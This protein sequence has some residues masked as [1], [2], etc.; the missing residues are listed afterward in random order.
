MSRFRVLPLLGLLLF[1]LP[2][3]SPVSVHAQEEEAESRWPLKLEG[4][5]GSIIIY[6]PQLESYSG[7]QLEA[8]AAVQVNPKGD[9][10]PVFGA[11]WFHC[12]LDTDMDT[13]TATLRELTITEA[14][15]PDA[16]QD[17]VDALSRYLEREVPKWNMEMSIDRLLAGMEIIEQRKKTTDQLNTEPPRIIVTHT[18]SVLILIDGDPI[19]AD[20]EDT[21]LKR[22]VNTPYFIVEDPSSKEYFLKG[23]E[24]W[25]RSEEILKG[26][27]VATKLPATVQAVAD[28]IA[29][30]EEKQREEEAGTQAEGSV[31]AA[32]TEGGEGKDATEPSQEDEDVV[33]DI[34]VSTVAA[35]LI[36]IDGDPSWTPIEETS[37]L[38]LDN[39]ESDVLMDIDSQLY[40]VLLAGRWYRSSSLEKGPW[41]YVSN[42]DLPAGFVTI[43]P[44][45]DMADV[46]AN[47]PGTPE[48]R[49]AVLETN[50]PQT[51]EVDRK[52]ATLTVEYD[53][54]PKFEAVGDTDMKYAVNTDK[55]VL[56]ID[57]RYYCCD[58]AIWFMADGPEGPWAVC[59]KVPEDV[60]SIP[61]DN[62]TYN[63]KYV[64]VYDSTP[65]VVYVGY[66]PG[67]IGSYVYGGCVVY[68]TGYHYRPWYHHYYYPRPVT[69]GF[70]VHYNPFTGWGFSFGLSYGWLNIGIRW[71]GYPYHG[72]WWGPAGYRY[73][74]RHGYA[75]GYRH[76]YHHGYHRGAR[77]GYAMGR[78]TGSTRPS[79]NLY[80]RQNNRAVRPG[81]GRTRPASGG[82]KITSPGRT[83]PTGKPA[84]RPT[85][86]GKPSGQGRPT[87]EARPSTAKRP[88]SAGGK[89]NVYADRQGN[90]YRNN[91]GNWERYD[92][93]NWSK[94]RA[95]SR[96]DRMSQPNPSRQQLDRDRAARQ[97][98]N[99]RARSYQSSRQRSSRPSGAAR[100]RGGGRRR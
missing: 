46:R 22:V 57:D 41:K 30:E 15:F 96:S 29:A 20:L 48:A 59:D 95:P 27:K 54:D 90:V 26:W 49:E 17:K 60:Q 50:I 13:R 56:L 2:W 71:G 66:T 93:G 63:V 5:K 53:G 68:G 4:E 44:D 7:N 34:I 45:S 99:E 8:R 62:P 80:R 1:L 74:Y 61:A 28:E 73:G 87:K 35:E 40:Y 88:T 38:Y 21:G 83:R 77:A 94:D 85:A 9:K 37:L 55:S 79:N 84:T 92:K 58:N 69:W 89:N 11:M 23:G 100:S 6:Q 14:K 25:Y 72:G 3:L 91:G 36:Q 81:G 52:E 19:L 12:R 39:T 42:D 64:Y 76:G 47:V 33:P 98:G 10:A 86:G 75:R 31:D 82:A 32:A 97:R 43:P 67:Y 51:A 16:P 70:G 78:R 65:D 24:H 18:P